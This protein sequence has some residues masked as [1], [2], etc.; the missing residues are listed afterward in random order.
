MDVGGVAGYQRSTVLAAI[1]FTTQRVEQFQVDSRFIAFNLFECPQVSADRLM[2]HYAMEQVS[3]V[4]SL[5]QA[6]TETV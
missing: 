1:L 4:T 5:N 6:R 3:I 2:Y